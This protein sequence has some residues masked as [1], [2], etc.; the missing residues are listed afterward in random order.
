MAIAAIAT[1]TGC[2][3]DEVCAFLDSRYGRHF[4]DDIA[5]GI[6]MGKA[7]PEAIAEA[8]R[9]WM[10]W[11]IGR[12][13]AR[14]IGIPQGLLYLTGFVVHATIAAEAAA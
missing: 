8:T 3:P 10:D 13:T 14:E 6:V 5:N 2:T 11:T 12:R 1:T 4:A 7:L 9:T